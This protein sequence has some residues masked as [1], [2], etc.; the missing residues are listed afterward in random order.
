ME[1]GATGREFFCHGPDKFRDGGHDPLEGAR[2]G[3]AGLACATSGP[4]H[5]LAWSGCLLVR[6]GR[7]GDGDDA[8]ELF[9]PR[10]IAR[11]GGD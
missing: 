4:E 6:Q 1:F 2:V 3:S 8:D 7:T 9:Q 5:R 11:I 10:V